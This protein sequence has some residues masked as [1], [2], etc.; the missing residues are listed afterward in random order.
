VGKKEKTENCE[1][2]NSPLQQSRDVGES[3]VKFVVSFTFQK[4][5]KEGEKWGE[6]IENLHANNQ[7]NV[8]R[9]S[10][11]LWGLGVFNTTSIIGDKK[12]GERIEGSQDPESER[13][14]IP[15]QAAVCDT[16]AYHVVIHRV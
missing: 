4:R 9:N 13:G 2:R 12:D 8:Q 7:E 3:F 10:K 5:Q 14:I 16:A 15:K 11:V 1:R 6:E